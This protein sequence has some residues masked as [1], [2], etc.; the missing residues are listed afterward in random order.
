MR[1][2]AEGEVKLLGECGR[3]DLG[4]VLAHAVKRR[5]RQRRVFLPEHILSPRVLGT[6]PCD[7]SPASTGRGEG[8]QQPQRGA[9]P[10]DV[11]DRRPEA[12]GKGIPGEVEQVRGL[13]F[14]G[15]GTRSLGS[16][17]VGLMPYDPRITRAPIARAHAVNLVPVGK[18]PVCD[19]TP[20]EPTSAGDKDPAH[21]G[22]TDV[23]LLIRR[24]R[25]RHTRPRHG[26]TRAAERCKAEAQGSA[27]EPAASITTV[28]PF[29]T[30]SSGS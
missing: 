27:A 15:H 17:Q 4:R 24:G 2:Q 8:V 1:P 23:A 30:L 12:T 20:D 6:G 22:R 9:D 19:A 7:D 18:E 10:F 29:P 26:T 13:C 21:S 3:R 5:G 25:S 28:K 11:L 14:R 16:E